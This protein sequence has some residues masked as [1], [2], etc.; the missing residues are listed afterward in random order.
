MMRNF[1]RI[2]KSTSCLTSIFE[3]TSIRFLKDFGPQC[4]TGKMYSR[5]F[6]RNRGLYSLTNDSTFRS[7]VFIRR[8]LILQA[9]TSEL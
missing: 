5:H 6:F 9:L 8:D 1:N 7:S 4:I 2:N 3:K